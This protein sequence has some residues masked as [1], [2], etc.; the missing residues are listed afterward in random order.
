MAGT[1]DGGLL[2]VKKIKKNDPDHFKKIGAMG[3]AHKGKKGFAANPKLASLAGKKGGH[4]G[5]RLGIKNR[6]KDVS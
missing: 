5:S 6:K 2:S 1:R 4:S 3:G